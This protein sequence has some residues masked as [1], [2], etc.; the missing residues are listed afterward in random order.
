MRD[1]IDPSA[2]LV[3]AESFP[4]F[5]C[6]VRLVCHSALSVSGTPWGCAE[7]VSEI[8]RSL[9]RPERAEGQARFYLVGRPPFPMGSVVANLS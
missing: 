9:V 1:T 5:V 8:G 7:R 4:L 3:N 2:S 6:V